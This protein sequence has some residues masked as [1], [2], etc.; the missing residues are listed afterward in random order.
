[1]RRSSICLVSGLERQPQAVEI[2]VLQGEEDVNTGKTG[3]IGLRRGLRI[4]RLGG[5]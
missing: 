5:S 1:M 4:K 2:L 3:M